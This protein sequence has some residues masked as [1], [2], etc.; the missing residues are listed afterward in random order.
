MS[1]PNIRIHGSAVLNRNE[2]GTISHGRRRYLAGIVAAGFS[3][4][5]GSS[6]GRFMS[7]FA[8]TAPAPKSGLIDVH[9]HIVPPFYLSENRERIV[10]A[11]G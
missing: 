8:Q 11:G 6:V 1:S 10:A 3:A 9:H 2:I 5:A 7:V 4:T